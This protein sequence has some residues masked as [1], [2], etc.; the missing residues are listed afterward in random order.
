MAGRCYYWRRVSCW[1]DLSCLFFHY[2]TQ[3]NPHPLSWLLHQAPAWFQQLSTA[4]NHF[5]ELIVPFGVFGPQRVRHVAGA[6]LVAFQLLLI[7]SGNLSFLNWLT[8]VVCLACFDDDVWCRLLPRRFAAQSERL[9]GGASASLGR[10]FV[11][12]SWAVVVAVLSLNPILNMLGPRQRMNAS[13]DPFHWVNTYGAF[14]SI[15]RVRHE[16][17][18]EGTLAAPTGDGAP[19]EGASWQAYEIPCK[20]GD[21]AR[22]PCWVTPYHYR[23]QWQMWFASLATVQREPWVVH[24]VYKLLGNEPM[25]LRLLEHNPFPD[26]PPRFVRARLFLYRFTNFGERGWWRREVVGE[27]LPPLS[28]D[29]PRLLGFLRAHG[30]PATP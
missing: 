26:E 1:T 29:D 20:P 28:R 25:A 22:R 12:A 27:Y 19:P 8:L 9:G 15:G 5:V 14:G 13:F 4:F 3:P 23:L 6:F 10:R 24:L 2:E 11:L 17:V 7:L 16:V 30:W 18:L 21:P